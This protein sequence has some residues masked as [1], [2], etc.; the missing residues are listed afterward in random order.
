MGDEETGRTY[1]YVQL[2]LQKT[3]RDIDELLTHVDG[4]WHRR[5]GTQ[6]LVSVPTNS[7]DDAIATL[8]SFPE[9][10]WVRRT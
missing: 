2:P 9:V 6:Y 7:A 10:L 3:E 8:E 5:G 4:E 1:L